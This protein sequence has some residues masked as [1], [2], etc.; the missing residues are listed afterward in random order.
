MNHFT[1]WAFKNKAAMTLFVIVILLIG[2]VSYF[3]LPMEFLPEADNPQVSVVTLG[4]GYD[5]TT[6][7][8]DI[9]DPIENAVSSVKGK[10]VVMSTTGDGYSQ[11]NINF[12][13]KTKMK[14]A[15]A[16]VQDA[17][18]S[19]QLPNGVEKPNVVQL[20][21]SMIPIAQVSLTFKDGLSKKDLDLTK[22]ELVP[23]YQDQSGISQAQVYGENS[24]HVVIKLDKDKMAKLHL[25]VQSVMGV[26]QGQDLAVSIGQ[27]PIDGKQSTIKVTG[28]LTSLG[29][30]KNLV[31]P[32][33]VPD[34]PVIHLKDVATVSEATNQ[35]VVTRLNGKNCIVLVI[36]KE[37]NA[38]AV[39][40][41]KQIKDTTEKINKDYSNVH[42]KTIFTTADMVQNSVSSMMREVL[43]GAL[44]ATVV[45][46]LFL[47]RLRPTIVTVVSIPLSLAITLLLLWLSGITLNILTLGG[48]AVAVGRLVDDSIVVVENVYRRSQLNTLTK[49]NVLKAT[50]EVS[51][52]ITASTLITV[53]VFL[54]IGLVSGSLRAL[55]LP[56]ALTVTYSLLAS[57]LVALTVVPLMS[58]GLLKGA[59]LPAHRKPLGYMKTLTWALNHKFIPILVA[60]LVLVGS[61]GLYIALPKGA[62]NASNASMISVNM[63]FPADTPKSEIKQKMTDFESQME[64]WKG[65]DFIVSLLGNSDG[66]AKYSQV[67]NPNTGQFS[68]ILKKNANAQAFL[69]KINLE[70]R[71]YPGVDITASP[72]SMMSTSTGT[73]ITYDLIGN[74]ANKLATTA[75]DL[76]AKIKPVD[77]VKKVSTN[78]D[79]KAPVYT[80][81]IDSSKANVQSL[82]MQLQTMINPTVI[83]TMTLNDSKVPVYLD[84]GVNPKS[85]SDLNKL[86]VATNQGIEPVSKVATLTEK[87]AS[88]TV[89]H[90]DG[91][92]FVR[93]SVEVNPDQLSVVAKKLALTV[94]KVKLP[95]GVTLV[96]GGA[97]TQQSSDFAD[98]G[99]TMLVSILLVYLIMVITFRTLRAPLAIL[100]TLPLAS[101]GAVLGLLI[102]KVPADPTALIGGLMLIGIVVTNAIVLIDR[103]K[104]N[105]ERM[106]I[107]EA[108]IE[109][110]GTRLRPVI[111]TAV[112]TICA[113]LPLLFSHNEDGSLV[114]KGLAVVVIGG[115]AVATVL[116]LI[117]VPVFYELLHFKKS[118]KQRL[119]A[120]QSLAVKEVM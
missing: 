11:V 2:V 31:I 52:A 86:L 18:S 119:E 94:N 101:I 87:K 111:M 43:L 55:I 83:G 12:D 61:V 17:I 95:K 96:K 44:F 109:A 70:K 25:P 97:E 68:I 20:N 66:A 60:I 13:S 41:G 29:A 46:L 7:A 36:F 42:D 32:T 71:H 62:I 22:N 21:T 114:S 53:A 64:S 3:R 98:L 100:M 49:E 118:K 75:K 35:D 34:A 39:L 51:R 90:K 54:P 76:M 92:T 8:K 45:I 48:V 105:E 85:K 4:Q 104:Q 69:N 16:E 1:K 117:I 115:L 91:K 93:V 58:S 99:M 40:A 107:R 15:K 116:T 102:S 6:M 38:S 89:L 74:D 103:V 19:L 28:N 24:P 33:Q 82:A 108:I 30:L 88:S 81:K 112:A 63:T 110:C 73:E 56:F 84:A 113:M 59:K 5:A 65:Y 79:E 14:D 57:L 47:R 106:I 9:T 77:G 80:F 10:T 26:L 67:G 78:E 120:G 37:D 72:S 50:A 27:K 23:L